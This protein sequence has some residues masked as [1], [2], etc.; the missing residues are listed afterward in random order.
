MKRDEVRSK[1]SKA[2]PG[3]SIQVEDTVPSPSVYGYRNHARLTSRQGML[4]FVSALSHRF[5]PVSQ[6]MLM[7]DGINYWLTKLQGNCSQ[8]SQVAIRSGQNSGDYLI[9]PTMDL[10]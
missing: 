10:S 3:I 9:Q 8:T 2:L 7:N 6:C 5:V 1:L 4:G